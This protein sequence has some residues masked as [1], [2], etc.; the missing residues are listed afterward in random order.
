MGTES[1]LGPIASHDRHGSYHDLA[2]S[3]KLASYQAVP[4]RLVGSNVIDKLF[5]V[6]VIAHHTLHQS[7]Y[8][9]T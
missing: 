3:V 4:G 7:N 1:F 9:W 6:P 5:V 8:S 2:T